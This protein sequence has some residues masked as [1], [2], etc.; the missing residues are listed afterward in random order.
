[1]TTAPKNTSPKRRLARTLGWVS[2]P[3]GI[4]AIFGV[5]CVDGPLGLLLQLGLL[6]LGVT[7]SANFADNGQVNF[8]VLAVSEDGTPIEKDD[9]NNPL[10]GEDDTDT[11]PDDTTGDTTGDAT[12]EPVADNTDVKYY[13]DVT[14]PPGTTATVET[15]VVEATEEVGT[16]S[17]ILDSSGSMER[18]YP[19]DDT[20]FSVC[21]TCPHDPDRQRVKATQALTREILARS[22]ESRL[23][24][25]DFG[26][27]PSEDTGFKVT[28]VLQNYTSDAELLKAGADKTV[29]AE[30]TFI[31]DST[32][33]VLDL[34]NGDIQ[35]HFQTKP[36]TKA[37]IVISDGEDT[38]ST[39]TLQEVIARANELEI[40]IHVVAIGQASDKYRESYQT[41]MDNTDIVTDFQRLANETGGFYATVSSNEDL[42][43]L[44]EAIALGLTGGYEKLVTTI[45]PIPSCGTVVK[46][47]IYAGDPTE[48]PEIEGQDWSFVAPCD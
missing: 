35:Q 19:P 5:G 20:G 12:D 23:G 24:I 22:P 43:A 41:D 46:G 48:N 32:M 15:V 21:A 33:E 10:G 34:M 9:S 17:V 25:F 31:Y 16:F 30:G 42:V 7:P 13:I 45:E 8:N 37:I 18:T 47:K 3:V 14:E 27:G 44:A 26:A 2:V 4:T 39:H 1:M 29:G 38:E 11:Q 6:L 36:I 40:P 28:R